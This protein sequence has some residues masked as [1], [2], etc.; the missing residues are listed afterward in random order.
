MLGPIESA[1]VW[2]PYT[3]SPVQG[4]R[5][6]IVR[7]EGSYLYNERGKAFFDATSSWWCCLHG[8]C[9]PELVEA[10]HRQASQLDQ[11][12]FAPHAHPVALGFAED[13]LGKLGPSFSKV[14]YSD[15]GSTSV[16]AGLKMALQYWV[17]KGQPNRNR[18]LSL[19]LG[20]HG[21]TLGAVSV[22][23]LDEFHRFFTPLLST[24]KSTAPYCYRCPYG[25]EYPTCALRCLEKAR[26][27]IQHHSGSIAALVVEPLVLGAGG[28]ITYP[29]A[30]L[31][32]LMRLCRE[33]GILVIF[34]EVFTGFGRTG[35]LF[36]MEQ[37]E[38]RPDIIC[39]SKGLTSG[40]LPL[41]V[42]ATS[43]EIFSAFQGSEKRK[44]Y[45]GH[46]FTANALGCA[47][48][49]QSLKLFEKN[50]TLA[51]NQKL[52]AYMA[53]Q[54][55]RFRKLSHVGDVRQLGMIWAVELVQDQKTKAA[56]RPANGPGWKISHAAWEK[57]VWFRPMGATLYVIPPYCSTQ[58]D[59]QQCFDV[60]YAEV[61]H[62]GHYE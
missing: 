29:A 51:H 19:E 8:H 44:F 16:E 9:H 46:T 27:Y 56:P 25:L 24:E 34:D 7:G 35:T 42:T 37:L 36:A 1:P 52:S 12:L 23:H 26:S 54:S 5:E 28:L 58:D 47:V 13:L 10:L 4:P 49:W 61:S 15:D 3:A 40:M 17:N 62:E 53:T 45:H 50:Q 48:A 38:L 18:F 31:N 20:Y 59:L 41:G 14:F 2:H 57:G 55:E 43:E 6:L 33:Q 32:E 22:G 39:L 11:I 60:L 21:D 30:Y